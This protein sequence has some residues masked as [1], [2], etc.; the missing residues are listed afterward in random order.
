MKSDARRRAGIVTLL[1][2]AA[3]SA[4]ADGMLDVTEDAR[5]PEPQFSSHA[6]V[7]LWATGAGSVNLQPPDRTHRHRF[8][9]VV[10]E[11]GA[12]PGPVEVNLDYWDVHTP[13][14]LSG[15][16]FHISG[17]R[18]WAV[19]RK[20]AN[21]VYLQGFASSLPL[22]TGRP[23]TPQP[24]FVCV[25]I[26]DGMGAGPDRFYLRDDGGTPAALRDGY[27]SGPG[28]F[29]PE[30]EL[31]CPQSLGPPPSTPALPAATGTDQTTLAF[32]TIRVY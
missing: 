26:E 27:S 21:R 30:P 7:T 8:N 29:V 10:R 14:P 17:T 18:I 15:A 32:G 31:E 19:V 6:G 5:A 3:V 24:R 28:T 9:F 22:T 1:L 11:I 25:W 2:T 12:A 13:P 23:G 20:Q 16:S 4:C